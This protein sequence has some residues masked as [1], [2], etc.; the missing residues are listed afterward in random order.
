VDTGTC[1]NRESS[2]VLGITLGPRKE[3]RQ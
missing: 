1:A 2:G 3:F